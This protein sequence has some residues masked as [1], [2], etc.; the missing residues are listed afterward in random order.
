MAYC[1]GWNSFSWWPL[2]ILCLLACCCRVNEAGSE[3]EEHA[4]E[5][6][7]HC[8]GECTHSVSIA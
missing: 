6:A 4:F 5:S 7:G 8:L 1:M 3:N 2:G